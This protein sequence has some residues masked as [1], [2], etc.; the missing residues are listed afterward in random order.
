MVVTEGS[1][2]AVA[3]SGSHTGMYAA[4][5][6]DIQFHGLAVGGSGIDTMTARRDAVLAAKPDLVSIYIG[7]NDI[8]PDVDG[9]IAKLKAYVDPI[10]AAGARVVICTL[11]P[12]QVTN[13]TYSAEF[14]TIRKQFNEK[15]KRVDWI[16][17][18]ADFGGH[19]IM[20]QDSAPFDRTYFEADG[21]HMTVAGH[22][23]VLTL[24][25]PAMDKLIADVR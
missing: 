12:K 23:Q 24:Y 13:V 15:M 2:S 25:K 6:S 8:G 3:W 19:P 22:T 7:S 16:D 1:S 21:Q 18:I 14:N 17:G 10:R 9:F 4:S 20:G 5:R 11:L